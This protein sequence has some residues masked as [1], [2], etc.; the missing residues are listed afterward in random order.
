M[1]PQSP[2]WLLTLQGVWLPGR[3][4]GKGSLVGGRGLAEGWV[5]WAG[6]QPWC[7]D[8]KGP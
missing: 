7:L 4:E 3:A 5:Y 2:Q 8:L 1:G 6:F